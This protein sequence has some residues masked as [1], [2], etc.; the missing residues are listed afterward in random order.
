MF[1]F[2]IY[3]RP[4]WYYDL[5][6]T[7]PSPVYIDLATLS[8]SDRN[9]IDENCNYEDNY[10]YKMDLSYQLIQ[11]GFIPDVSSERIDLQSIFIT[12]KCDNYRFIKRHFGFLKAV[13]VLFIRIILLNSPITEV[14]AFIKTGTQHRVKNSKFKQYDSFTNFKSNLLDQKPL[15]SVVIPTLNR[16]SYL[17]VVLSDLERQTYNHFEVLIC[18]QSDEIDSSFY[19]GWNLDIKLI[20]Q[21]EKAL[22]LARNRCIE[23]AEG[24]YIALT[25][26]DVRLPDS[27]L[28]NHLKCIDFFGVNVSCGIFFSEGSMP[29]KEHKSFRLSDIFATG[30]TLINRN[31]FYKT[32]LFDRQFEGQRMG[33]GEF[34]LRCLVNDERL[35]LN[36]FAFCI[37]VKAPVGGLRE[38]GSWDALRPR[39]LLAPRPYPSVLY[40]ARNYFGTLNAIFYMVLNIPFS[41]IPYKYK[42]SKLAKGL[43]LL[44]LPL[45]LPL[46]LFVSVKS[47]MLASDKLEQGPIIPILK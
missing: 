38:M 34:G 31:V 27:W 25:E 5:C 22:W 46:M 9:L 11:A 44:I 4:V 12:H 14:L 17:K 43:S 7:I 42:H 28:E 21:N 30:N 18:D 2:L 39:N 40:Y 32:G 47:W 13:Y 33:D 3:V 26:D 19:S 29:A 41:F 35:I 10:S 45:V 20:K 24:K 23:E 37:D 15:V 16:Y 6:H 1:Q 8:E 36:P